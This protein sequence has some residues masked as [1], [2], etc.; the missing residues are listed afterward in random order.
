MSSWFASPSSRSP[1]VPKDVSD[2]LLTDDGGVDQRS[3]L[4]DG[5]PQV[6]MDPSVTQAEMHK[7]AIVRSAILFLVFGVVLLGMVP[8]WHINIQEEVTTSSLNLILDLCDETAPNIT[9]TG[10]NPSAVF[11]VLGHTDVH[12]MYF[13]PVGDAAV[14]LGLPELLYTESEELFS[15][16]TG[17]LLG[18]SFGTFSAN[19]VR[20]RVILK[21]APE[22]HS[23]S[24]CVAKIASK[25]LMA[26]VNAA[27]MF[28]Q[29]IV[30]ALRIAGRRV[31]KDWLM[32]TP[33]VHGALLVWMGP[34]KIWSNAASA[35][36]EIYTPS[37]SWKT[38]NTVV[39]V[40]RVLLCAT[41]LVVVSRFFHNIWLEKMQIWI[42]QYDYLWANVPNVPGNPT[43]GPEKDRHD[44]AEK[45]DRSVSANELHQ[46][47][48]TLHHRYQACSLFFILDHGPGDPQ[49][50]SENWLAGIVS[51]VLHA[52]VFVLV[53]ALPVVQS[54]FFY[55]LKPAVFFAVSAYSL[56]TIAFGTTYY[57]AIPFSSRQLLFAAHAVSWVITFVWGAYYFTSVVLFMATRVVVDTQETLKYAMTLG[58]ALAYVFV[59]SAKLGEL[60]HLF[61]SKVFHKNSKGHVI[62]FLK[63]MGLDTKAIVF[64]VTSGFVLIILFSAMIVLVGQLYLPKQTIVDIVS[65]AI[66]PFTTLIGTLELIKK[67]KKDMLVVANAIV[68]KIDDTL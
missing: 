14:E 57:F 19:Q 23:I 34:N 33:Q 12:L 54:L 9:G 64:T 56:S 43:V 60:R 66:T 4:R 32:T 17:R 15:G 7:I 67:K 42:V 31:P 22:K 41:V 36:V 38:Y 35:F 26:R 40:L 5:I 25:R 51:A 29:A 18:Y 59:A 30:A 13:A 28:G 63:F 61:E 45:R 2:A 6:R 20:L 37:I 44:H 24:E 49:K 39:R 3:R 55:E 1:Q 68:E 52:L 65:A 50:N 8:L 62:K 11:K 47:T 27:D 53:A 48:K 46:L 21:P 58:S 16:G 10:L